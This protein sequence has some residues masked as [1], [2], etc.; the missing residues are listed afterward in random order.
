LAISS[1]S[2]PPRPDATIAR[3]SGL[4]SDHSLGASVPR[5]PPRLTAYPARR[6]PGR[7]GFRFVCVDAFPQHS[8]ALIAPR[9]AAWS[10]GSCLHAI[11]DDLSMRG[12]DSRRYSQRLSSIAALAIV[13]LFS[14]NT[15]SR[16]ES[17]AGTFQGVSNMNV[18]TYVEANL[19]SDITYTY[20]ASTITFTLIYNSPRYQSG[21][22]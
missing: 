4:G 16:A 13:T 7:A 14:V 6:P 11:I 17:I 5:C 21:S 12:E 19:V 3:R 2:C 20:V 18:T 15:P 22:Y 10:H 9:F 1:A 8:R